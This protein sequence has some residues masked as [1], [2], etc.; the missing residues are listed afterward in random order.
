MTYPEISAARTTY[1]AISIA[2]LLALG[3][4]G[5]YSVKIVPGSVA[6]IGLVIITISV[7]PGAIYLASKVRGSAPFFA[8]TS[9]FYGITFGLPVFMIPLGW[10]D[11]S[12]IIMYS[13]LAVPE[14]RIDVLIIVALALAAFVAVFFASRKYIFFKLPR[15]RFPKSMDQS[16]IAPLLWVLLITHQLYEFRPDVFGVYSAGQFL[17]PAG[18]VAFGGFYLF[19]RRRGLSRIEPLLL[20]VVF[21]PIELYLRLRFLLL[22]DLLF[23]LIFFAF[24]LWRE[25]NY[26]VLGLCAVL[27]FVVLT[28]YGTA[29]AVRQP[30]NAGAV[31]ILKTIKS[32]KILMI[33]DE[34]KMLHEGHQGKKDDPT[35]H[36]VFV[37]KFGSLTR[38]LSNIWIFHIVDDKTPAELPHW[39]GSSYLPVFTAFIPRAIFPDKPEERIGHKFGSDYGFIRRADTHMSINL[40]WITELLVNFG[41]A[42]VIW[43]MALIGLFYAFLDRLFNAPNA[44][45]LETVIGLTL[46]FPLVYPESNFSVMTGSM[47]PLFV[48]LFI[49]FTGGAWILKRMGWGK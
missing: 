13:R 18:Y 31:N 24:L 26:K 3:S 39:N 16:K 49:Y 2:G 41:K 32:Y 20:L 11:A 22:T 42:G 7:L 35:I 27:G 47:A 19:W 21:L 4:V 45:E 33:D 34:D 17:D 44:T 40:P 5:L 37:G 1:V 25:G 30:L 48:S 28:A 12:S 23:F 15:F 9:L 6:L 46:I 10:K 14:I 29:T 43:G 36:Y 8:V 38:R